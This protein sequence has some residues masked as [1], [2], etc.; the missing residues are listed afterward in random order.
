M[1]SLSA[2]QGS[3]ARHRGYGKHVRRLPTLLFVLASV[4]TV[5]PGWSG[6]SRLP[7]LGARADMTATW[8]ALDPADR[9]RPRLGRLT[10][11]GGAVLRSRDPAFGGYSAL[12]VEGDRFTLLSDGGN[13]VRFRMGGDWRPADLSFAHLPDGPGKGWSK[14]DR[15]SESLAID[16]VTHTAW[17]GFEYWNAIGRYRAAGDGTP[18]VQLD[19]LAKPEA[20]A[21]WPDN[22]GPE[23]MTRLR[24][25]RF[26]VI[27][28]TARPRSADGRKTAGRRALLFA[29]DPV[30]SRSTG[31]TYIPPAGFS[32]VDAAALPDGRLII[33]NRA[34]AAPFA[35]S[36]SLAVLDTRAIRAG[37]VVP[38]REIARLAAPL[39]HDNFEGIAVS[40]EGDDTVIWIVSDD[41][42][43]VLERTMLLKFRLDR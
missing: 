32:P 25:G 14:R 10:Y 19:G 7:V 35:F 27:S 39:V 1:R 13:I 43:T 37:A 6:E 11:L 29:G 2:V 38:G 31:F 23:T 22:G 16:P 12:A 20:M 17:V 42:E 18:L 40:R 41:N 3:A 8:V 21:D 9:G 28:E 34:F 15:D 24:D 5:V 36:N 26:V 30:A 4:E 33:M